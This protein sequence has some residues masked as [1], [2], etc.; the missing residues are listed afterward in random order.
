[1]R[2]RMGTAEHPATAPVRDWS[3]LLR[4]Q[5]VPD[6]IDLGSVTALV[7]AGG[8]TASAVASRKNSFVSGPTRL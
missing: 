1:M 6:L 7:D 8:I 5:F 4:I 3:A 2:V